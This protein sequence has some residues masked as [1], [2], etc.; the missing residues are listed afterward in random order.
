MKEHPIIWFIL[1]CAWMALFYWQPRKLKR[2]IKKEC[3]S[4]EMKTIGEIISWCYWGGA[5]IIAVYTVYW[6][7]SDKSVYL[8][9]KRWALLGLLPFSAIEIIM[10]VIWKK[11]RIPYKTTLLYVTE[12]TKTSL[13]FTYSA[14]AAIPIFCLIY[15]VMAICRYITNL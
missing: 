10:F 8:F 9:F 11:K 1:Y 3:T 4:P 5:S 15:A 2:K 12:A 14:R 13:F 6:F 7:S